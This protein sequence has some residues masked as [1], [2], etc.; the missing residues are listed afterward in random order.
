MKPRLPAAAAKRLDEHRNPQSGPVAAAQK[1]LWEALQRGDIAEAKRQADI[2]QRI[3]GPQPPS[4]LALK[5]IERFNRLRPPP[6]PA[7]AT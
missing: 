1:A 4:E 7:H 5:L 3:R 6:E 2:V